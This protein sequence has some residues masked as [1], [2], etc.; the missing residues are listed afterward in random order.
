MNNLITV[1]QELLDLSDATFEPIIHQDAIVAIVYKITIQGSSTPFILKI[2]TRSRDYFNEIYFLNYF[3]GSLIPVPRIIKTISPAPDI[4][5]ALLMEYIPGTLLTL[6]D[7]T[8]ELAY[9]IGALLARIHNNRT[10]GYGDLTQPQKLS[11]NPRV[12]FTEKFEEGLAECAS[13][14]PPT[15]LKECRAYFN[16][17]IDLLSVA[18][19]PCIV[20]RDFR[21][22]N[23]IINNGKVQGIIDWAAARSSFAQEDFCSLGHNN[24]LTKESHKQL[25]LKGYASIRPIP[26]YISMLMPLLRLSKAIAVIGFTVKRGTWQTTDAQL[27]RFNRQFLETLLT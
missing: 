19:G 13:H 15:I 1:Y 6:N 27:Y 7:L 11:Q 16:T 18:D 9:E 20:H 3:A 12:Y 21:P 17:Y 22:G 8:D 23:L 2:C 26:E 10:A 5:G 25:F 24:W 4:M 14:L